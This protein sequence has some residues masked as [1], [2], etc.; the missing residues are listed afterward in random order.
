ML[1]Q[2]QDGQRVDLVCRAWLL[3]CCIW[4]LG[5]LNAFAQ[6]QANVNPPQILIDGWQLEL[7]AAEPD[8]VTPTACCFDQQGRLFVIECHTH[9]PPGDY[10][11]PQ[12]DRI[13]VFDDTTGDGRVDRQR[14]FHEGSQATMGLTATAD[15]SLIVV[16]RQEVLRLRDTTGDD[17]ADEVKQL[18][19]LETATTYPHNGLAGVAVGPDGRLYVGQGEN[20]G[21]AYQ[22]VGSD[23]S[24]QT[25]SGEG[26]NIFVCD[27]DGSNVERFATG[28]WNPFGI[29]FDSSGRLWQ[30]GNDP[31][32]MPPCRLLHV[33]KGGDYGFQF[34]FGRAGTHPLQA[35]N[36]ELP[37]TLPMTAGTGEAPC[38]VIAHEGYLW[39]TS[40]GDNRLERYT[41]TSQ[42]AS[43]SSGTEVVVQGTGSFRPVG[44]AVAPDGALYFTDWV[45]RSYPVHG[46]GRLWRFSPPAT[47][48][49]ASG[50]LPELSGA[51]RLARRLE[52][53]ASM[54]LAERLQELESDDPFLRHAAMMGLLATGQLKSLAIDGSM[55]QNQQI[56]F[57]LAHR[58][59]EL[60]NPEAF[61][62]R[63]RNRLLGWGLTRRNQETMLTAIR[64]AAE[65]EVKSFLPTLHAL[66]DR[67][68]LNHQT[69]AAVMAAIAY[70]ETGSVARGRRDPAREERLVQYA[71]DQDKPIELRAAA[72]ELLPSD[73]DQPSSEELARWLRQQDNRLFQIAVGRLLASRTDETTYAIL[74]ELAADETI[75]V[76]TRADA[77]AALAP[78]AAKFAAVLNRLALPRQKEPLRQEANRILQRGGQRDAP[79]KPSRDDLA[80]WHRL[81]GSG[82]NP[83]AGRRVFFRTTCANCHAHS[84]RGANTGPDLTTLAGQMTPLRVLESILQP[85]KEIGPLYVAY[86]VLTQEGRILTGLKLD[87]T[88]AGE[89]L[90]MQG[91]DGDLFTVPLA[92]IESMQPINQ[93]IM[94]AGLEEGLSL[95]EMRDLVAF[96]TT[97]K[98]P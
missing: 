20:F 81:T 40:W 35:W 30:A 57:L 67:P 91:A 13:Y 39:V 16:T 44:L 52:G 66:L 41:L 64:W 19:R 55:T 49:A 4:G 84:H 25:G 5:G 45:D 12:A 61:S 69:F 14:L 43:W 31:D 47:G 85:S 9:F 63:E 56:A 95:A 38:A 15:G 28:L 54:P 88:K 80:G 11:G 96:L 29:S 6:R 79:S 42:G 8:L 68:D 89:K 94:P 37:G 34:R 23:A 70:L 33:V 86:R 36:G 83:D 46:K 74:A 24:L 7:V 22:L 26:G 53:D 59:R 78:Q 17:V 3:V 32:A 21:E 72:V 50:W 98:T 97:P 18:L 73:S 48:G 2:C 90:V 51:E 76:E 65:R 92:D 10:P 93:S 62:Q 77:A 27:A 82:G 60:T 87:A 71:G 75:A 1:M 58:W